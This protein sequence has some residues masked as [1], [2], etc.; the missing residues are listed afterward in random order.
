VSEQPSELTRLHLIAYE[1][2]PDPV[3]DF[4]FFSVLFSN[5]EKLF[6]IPVNF[7][8]LLIFI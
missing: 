8:T 2:P 5:E 4:K 6:F 7:F 3:M 1:L